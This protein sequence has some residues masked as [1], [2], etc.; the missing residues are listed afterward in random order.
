MAAIDK[1]ILHKYN[2]SFGSHY[3]SAIFSGVPQTLF[4]R[5]ENFT[6]PDIDFSHL[7][8]GVAELVRSAAGIGSQVNIRGGFSSQVAE[9]ECGQ[10]FRQ[11]RPLLHDGFSQ[12]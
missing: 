1:Y 5:L 12:L 9:L 8:R 7:L 6:A 4:Q 11:F 3:I 2:S 10:L